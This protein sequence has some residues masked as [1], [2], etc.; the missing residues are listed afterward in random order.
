M[1]QCTLLIFVLVTGNPYYIEGYRAPVLWMCEG[2]IYT[3]IRSS[4]G[5]NPM[6]LYISWHSLLME[7]FRN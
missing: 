2:N 6:Q 3:H 7:A 5:P 1:V 4:P